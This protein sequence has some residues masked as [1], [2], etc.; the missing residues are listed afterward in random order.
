MF[1]FGD[2]KI[3][4]I[5]LAILVLGS[6]FTMTTGSIL[7]LILTLPA[8]LIA[9]TFH[10]YAHAFVAVKLGDDTPR[11]QGRLTLNPFAHLDPIGAVLLVF[12]HFG[13]GKPVEINP[14]NFSR[15]IS[16]SAGEAI[17][18]LAG[19]LMNFI[20]AIVFTIISCILVKFASSFILFNQIGAIIYTLI[21]IC[22]SI[23]I[24][25]GVFNLIP[26]P[27]LDGSKILMHFL[28]YN[29]KNWMIRN[30]NIFYIVFLLIWITGL[31]GVIISPVIDFIYNI[32]VGGIGRLFG[33]L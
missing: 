9:I 26:L 11:I 24:G 4:Y 31:A 20:L 27:P 17:V 10:E 28:P 25:L 16:M 2:K 22:I 6:I 14:R 33:I 12:V 15:K 23:N 1:Y 32:I 5:I 30:Q 18:S 29:A 8:V 21:K 19:P 7:S 3:I 13:W